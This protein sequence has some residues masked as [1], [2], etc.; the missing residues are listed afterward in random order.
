MRGSQAGQS[1]LRRVAMAGGSGRAFRAMAAASFAR[2]RTPGDDIAAGEALLSQ[3]IQR[4]QHQLTAPCMHGK[5]HAF[6]AVMPSAT[7]E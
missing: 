3:D 4:R 2:I 1:R 6:S 5:R 7:P